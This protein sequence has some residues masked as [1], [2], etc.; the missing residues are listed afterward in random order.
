MHCS[1]RGGFQQQVRFLRQQFL[2]EDGLPF[3]DVLSSEAVS[4]AVRSIGLFWMERIYTPLTTL[5]VFLAQVL[6]ADHSCRSAVARLIAQR[7]SLGQLP[8]SAETG[9]Y[10]QARKRL[11]EKFFSGVARQTGQTLDARSDSTW[12]WKGHRVYIY[13]G[14][15][16][17][18]PDT[19]E[20]QRAYP[21]N[22]AQKP[23][24]GFP[25]ARIGAIFS[26]A[27]GAVV[28]LGICRYAGKG[29]GELNLLHT[30]WSFFRDGDVVLTDRLM[31]TWMEI[32]LLKSR[33][34]DS[35]TQLHAWRK[36][37]FRRGQ[38]LGPGDHLVCW[39]RPESRSIIE[40]AD[41]SLPQFMTVRECRIRVSQPGFRSKSIVVVTTLL[42]HEKYTPDDLAQLYLAR[43]NA[44]VSQAEC[45]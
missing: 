13:D 44:E 12:R 6:S 9:A 27:C 39:G 3:G 29:Q 23:G 8:C 33:G 22:V 34:I 31:C 25:I 11:P 7:I 18:M 4:Q 38:R 1:H 5:W 24:L 2:Q 28:E 16:V 45:R 17:T 30:L 42:D 43:W 15:T 32:F 41:R 37:D 36:S 20:N 40:K 26:L 21:Q 35:V 10:C 19:L 14:S